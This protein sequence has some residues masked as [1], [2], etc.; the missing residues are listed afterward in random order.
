MFKKNKKQMAPFISIIVIL[1]FIFAATYAYFSNLINDNASSK[2]TVL[3]HTTDSFVISEGDDLE[4]EASQFNFSK[5]DGNLSSVSTSTIDLR[6]STSEAAIYCYK[7]D[8]I[9]DSNSFIYTTD[10]ETPE[11]IFK[12]VKNGVTIV[13]NFDITTKGTSAVYTYQIPTTSGGSTYIH[14]LN[15][16]ID[17]LE[18]DTFVSTVTFVN[19]VGSQNQNTDKSFLGRV[20]FTKTNCI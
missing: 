16:D 19:L 6:A 12:T 5:K 13:N 11:L 10:E 18:T 2:V 14:T 20:K 15:A 8:L 17:E 1:G 7:A 9:I 3:L 4:I